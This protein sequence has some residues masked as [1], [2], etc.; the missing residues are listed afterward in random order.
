MNHNDRNTI[1]QRSTR[2]ILPAPIFNTNP[3]P[4]PHTPSPSPSPSPP[5]GRTI[6]STSPSFEI[7]LLPPTPANATYSDQLSN[8]VVTVPQAPPGLPFEIQ[9]LTPISPDPSPSLGRD[10][11][12]GPDPLPTRATKPKTSHAKKQPD[13][14]V[15]RPR[16]AFIL[17]RCWFVQNRLLGKDVESDHRKISKIVGRVWNS[18][19]KEDKAHWEKQAREE[20]ERHRQLYPDYRYSPGYRKDGS[21]ASAAGP[22]SRPAATSDSAPAVAPRRRVRAPINR[23]EEKRVRL[24]AKLVCGGAGQDGVRQRVKDFDRGVLNVDDE[25]DSDITAGEPEADEGS[26]FEES[27]SKKKAQRARAR[28]AAKKKPTTFPYPSPFP[29]VPS[30]GF[31]TPSHPAVP[32]THSMTTRRRSLSTPS[33]PTVPAISSTLR[34]PKAHNRTYSDLA[35]G[36]SSGVKI[37]KGRTT[38]NSMAAS[39]VFPHIPIAKEEPEDE[40]LV[41]NPIASGYEQKLVHEKRVKMQ[42]EQTANVETRSSTPFSLSRLPTPFSS[43]STPTAV[44]PSLGYQTPTQGPGPSTFASPFINVGW[45][46]GPN[47]LNPASVPQDSGSQLL[48]EDFRMYSTLGLV[49]DSSDSLM[50]GFEFEGTSGFS[51]LNGA[52]EGPTSS[53]FHQDQFPVP[54]HGA[55]PMEEVPQPSTN[56]TFPSEA[57][58]GIEASSVFDPA[59]SLN[60]PTNIAP[61]LSTSAPDPVDPSPISEFDCWLNEDY[62]LSPGSGESSSLPSWSTESEED[63]GLIAYRR[64]MDAAGSSSFF[65]KTL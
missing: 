54:A 29:P 51:F 32:S 38:N 27:Q 18:L 48:Q 14:H 59:Y 62:F 36:P 17:F 57:I 50:D 55:G 39:T 24:I 52:D 46:L 7:G 9:H 44:A 45:A 61:M 13:G 41:N 47:F 10:L 16:N 6:I 15:R 3:N 28:R 20:K 35:A 26:D 2:N 5:A 31:P 37:A 1:P 58:D 11:Q 33:L 22:S 42:R 65:S 49:D 34:R 21:S 40:V 8:P 53:Y 43:Q 60:G 23:H 30:H 64:G 56:F 63:D 4:F 12:L 19:S 25:D